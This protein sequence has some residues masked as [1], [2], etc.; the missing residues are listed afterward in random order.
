MITTAILI[1]SVLLAGVFALMW[2]LS[3][4]FRRRIERPK[5]LFADRVRQYDEDSRKSAGTSEAKTSDSQ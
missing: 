2:I 4:S 1:G 5:H 3:P